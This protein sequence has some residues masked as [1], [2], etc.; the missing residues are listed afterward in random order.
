MFSFSCWLL[1][2]FL[3]AFIVIVRSIVNH[4]VSDIVVASEM[5]VASEIIDLDWEKCLK[6]VVRYANIACDHAK[7]R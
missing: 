6:S 1:L 2:L 5:V 4:I 7:V 3:E